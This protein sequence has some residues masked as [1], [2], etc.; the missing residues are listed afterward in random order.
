MFC[1]NCGNKIEN[2]DVFCNKCGA[3]V[4]PEMGSIVFARQ[5]KFYGSLI[6]IKVFIDGNL[7]ATVGNGKEE[8]VQVSV[9]KHKLAFN[10]WSGNDVEDIELT[11]E[12]PNIKINFALKMGAVTSKPKIISI[13]NL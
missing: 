12:H 2:N 8:K 9:G 7:V 3:K 13:E 10:L 5:S 4:G 6:P 1:N 11:K